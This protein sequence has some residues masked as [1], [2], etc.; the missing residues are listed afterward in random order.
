[1]DPNLAESE[2]RSMRPK[3]RDLAKEMHISSVAS[4]LIR[5]S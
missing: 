3:R 2:A 4:A 1:V 5:M